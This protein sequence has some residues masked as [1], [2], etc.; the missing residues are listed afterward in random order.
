MKKLILIQILFLAVISVSGQITNSGTGNWNITGTWVGNIIPTENDNVETRNN[1]TITIS[2]GDSVTISELWLG[3]NSVIII[4]G[5]LVMDSL[6]INNNATL[7]VSGTVYILGGATLANNTT[8]TVNNTGTVDITGDVDTGNGSDLVVDGD[9]TIG[10]DLTGDATLAGTGSITVAGA[11]D[12][13]IDDTTDNL[14]PIE[15]TY[16]QAYHNKNH[17][18]I[19]W[20]TATEENNDY[21]TVERSSDGTNY[22][23]IGTVLGAGN[24]LTALNYSYTD[25][26]PVNGVSYYR[27]MQTDYD[28]VF[29]VFSPVSVSYLNE[30]D[31]KIGPN[32]VINQLDISIGGEMG[33]GVA[34]LYNLTGALVKTAKLT[35]NNTSL[36]VKDLPA[37]NYMMVISAGETN[38]SRRIVVK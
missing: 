9:M 28:G 24:S 34:N 16:F 7:N 8:L 14:L 29:E 22:E 23:I 12:P 6:H 27:L 15:L 25:N 30:G 11:V 33:T 36:D 1:D 18:N 10:G 2:V 5:I 20:Q 13:S 3:N 37:G 17:V 26:K 35:S 32:P 21:F 19:T 38:I 31:L 4:D